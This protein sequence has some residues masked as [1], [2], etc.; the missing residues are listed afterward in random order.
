VITT[1]TPL[2][3]AEGTTV[4]IDGSFTNTTAVKFNGVIAVFTVSSSTR[5]IATVPAGASTGLITVVTAVGE[6]TSRINFFVAPKISGFTPSSGAAGTSV[7]GWP[8]P[9][10]CYGDHFPTDFSKRPRSFRSLLADDMFR[11]ENRRHE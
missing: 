1:F 8:E 9:D 3:G 6:A 5:L 7:T 10:N 4:T 11:K 2:S